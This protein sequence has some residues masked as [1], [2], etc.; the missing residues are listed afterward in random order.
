MGTKS[1]DRLYGTAVRMA[2]QRAAEARREADKFACD[3]WTR[4]M[5]AFK[6]PA[7]PAPTLG[8]ALN[9][10][11]VYL[12]VRC[13]GCDT[14]Q[15]RRARHRAAPEDDAHPRAGTLLA[16]QG[17][18][19]GARLSAFRPA[20]S[21]FAFA[22]RVTF[23]VAVA[24]T[25]LQSSASAQ[26]NLDW[27]SCSSD[28]DASEVRVI[29]DCTELLKDENLSDDD[30]AKVYYNRAEANWRL[31]HYD[32]AIYD[33]TRSIQ[34]KPNFSD[35]YNR[36]GA[37][38]AG[39][40]DYK[41]AIADETRAIEI[42]PNNI[43]AYLDRSGARL[44]EQDW[45]GA[46]ADANKALEIDPRSIAGHLALAD[47]LGFKQYLASAFAEMDKAIAIV[48]T[49]GF[50]G[51][52]F[53]ALAL[54][55]KGDYRRAIDA[56]NHWIELSP[57]CAQAYSWR[58]L[59]EEIVGNAAGAI[60][61]LSKALEI[62]PKYRQALIDRG[63]VYSRRHAFDQAIADYS[64]AIAIRPDDL[65]AYRLR[66]LNYAYKNDFDHAIADFTKLIKLNPK[67]AEAY[68]ERSAAH[69]RKRENQAALADYNQAVEITRRLV[70]E[71]EKAFLS[72]HVNDQRPR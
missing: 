54:E 42:D 17:L 47:A 57:D 72:T 44:H 67:D 71:D 34:L 60:K 56:I 12:E 40:A 55:R 18:L 31:T 30:R 14:H 24:L 5:L 51:Y 32:A 23:A 62:E 58:A 28:D 39:K 37:A 66:G 50:Q 15:N 46:M 2:A 63:G 43:Q 41:S 69:A 33:A 49:Q 36:R 25:F 38:Y 6:G 70:E 65:L 26:S 21:G 3:A 19:G 20:L 64:S 16:V 59:P 1:R 52:R 7:Q 13:L 29:A 11:Y 53:Q 9:A 48:P 45:T 27:K 10:G 68:R 61:D 35:P 8:D 4:R 22:M